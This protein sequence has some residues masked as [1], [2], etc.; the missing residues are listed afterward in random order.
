MKNRF[1]CLSFFVLVACIGG[2]SDQERAVD[3]SQSQHWLCLPGDSDACDV[4]LSTT[5]VGAAGELVEESWQAN[6][7][8]DVDCFYV[9]PTVSRDLSRTSDLQAGPEELAVVRA[10]AAR[11]GA[12]CRVFAPIY[13]Q[14]TLAGLQAHLMAGTEPD[15]S[16]GYH[17]VLAAW[18][19]YLQNYNNG[20]GVVLIGHS[21]GA[22]V[23]TRLVQSEIENKPIQ[24][25]LIS[26]MLIGWRIE[27]PEGKTSGG[28]FKQL[29]LCQQASETGCVV[30]YSAFRS[31]SPPPKDAL[32]GYAQQGHVAACTD[33]AVLA[34]QPESL[35]SYLVAGEGTS[36]SRAAIGSWV[37]EGGKQPQT[38]FVSVPGLLASDCVIKEKMSYLEVTVQ[39]DSADNRTD[40]I[41]GDVVFAG[42]VQKK[43]GLHLIDMEL[44]MGNLLSL[45]Q[46]Q[47]E[48]YRQ[49][50]SGDS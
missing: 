26:A 22:H 35:H 50:K 19:Y 11:F 47:A 6:P 4:D 41:A 45:L 25:Q 38:P 1:H 5:V 28:T 34:G 46:Q 21:Q 9:Y 31:T 33:P 18:Q 17:D 39:A 14:V 15:M 12:Q 13:R 43:W 2:C 30:A 32:F 10:Q 29:P 42:K 23:L 37:L 3:Y 36:N 27:V 7:D 49:G 16:F 48:S 44:A 8:T 24:S 40:D 20:R